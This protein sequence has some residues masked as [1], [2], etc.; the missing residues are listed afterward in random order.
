MEE[1]KS[2]K[3]SLSTFFLLLAII[4]IIVMAY[5]IYRERTNYN[6]ETANSE[7][8]AINSNTNFEKHDIEDTNNKLS[9]SE[10]D[11]I[12][13]DL[14]EKGSQKI[15]EAEYF[16]LTEYDYDFELP[17]IEKFINGASYF[18]TDVLYSN[19]EEEYSEIFTGEALQKVLGKR[20]IEIDGY[21]YVSIGGATG[22]NIANIKVSRVSESNNEIEYIVTYNDVRIDDSIS[23]KYSC[24]MTIKLIDGNYRISETNYCDLN[25]ND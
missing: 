13:M 14:F 3:I 25:K 4:V 17:F 24:E 7:A 6:K 12:A 10:V 21:L 2:F 20:F 22:W 19:V 8:N 1:K 23:E 11:K 15:R 9:D 16:I 18:K 5:Y